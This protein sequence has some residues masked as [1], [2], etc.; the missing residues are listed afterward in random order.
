MRR[1]LQKSALHSVVLGAAFGLVATP[2]HAQQI[3]ASSPY[4]AQQTSP[5]ANCQR[6]C[7]P[8]PPS[9]IGGCPT[10]FSVSPTSPTSPDTT[11]PTTP[12]TTPET[13]GGDTTPS[14]DDSQAA[15]V[16][17][18]AKTAMIGDSLGP[19]ILKSVSVQAPLSV[20]TFRPV[21]DPATKT[22]VSTPFTV[23]V[24]D[25]SGKPVIIT[26]ATNTRAVNTGINAIN[27]ADDQTPIP[28]DRVFFIY[29][30]FSDATAPGGTFTSTTTTTNSANGITTANNNGQ[31]SSGQPHVIQ[32]TFVN[33]ILV[34]QVTANVPLV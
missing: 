20:T 7:C 31:F 22:I 15:G 30:G 17:V 9:S 5:T 18:G 16:G 1:L 2:A 21:F 14:F 33:G 13:P 24:T 12:G 27:I 6:P 28:Q 19:P 23:P 32:E 10:P 4:F 8:P 26:V 29:N 11:A 3:P 25:P 34:K